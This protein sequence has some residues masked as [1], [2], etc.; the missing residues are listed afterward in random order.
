MDGYVR[1][2]KEMGFI[3]FITALH[4]AGGWQV[5]VGSLANFCKVHGKEALA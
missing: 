2:Y 3:Y 1:G 4:G 5:L